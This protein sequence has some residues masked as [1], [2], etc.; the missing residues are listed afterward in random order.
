MTE[1]TQRKPRKQIDYGMDSI[2][3]ITQPPTPP[4]EARGVPKFKQVTNEDIVNDPERNQS[5]PIRQ[6][7]GIDFR[8]VW[9]RNMGYQ[10]GSFETTP[11]PTG[12]SVRFLVK[13][14]FDSEHRVDNW[15]VQGYDPN[16]ASL[17]TGTISTWVGKGSRITTKKGQQL[18]VFRPNLIVRR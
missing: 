8:N 7:D 18:T 14:N 2:W 12:G 13:P 3:G 6:V 9:L 5:N 4:P 17:G 1:I 10:P 15:Y 16:G 11:I